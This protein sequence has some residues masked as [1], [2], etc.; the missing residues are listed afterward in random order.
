MLNK[1]AH[2]HFQRP[3]NLFTTTLH[4]LEKQNNEGA[5][6]RRKTKI[7]KEE[8][9]TN[10]SM[11]SILSFFVSIFFGLVGLEEEEEEEKDTWHLKKYPN[12]IAEAK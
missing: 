4:V 2:D 11:H 6:Q 8:H 9:G 12:T 1:S 10:K 5:D 3:R 7:K